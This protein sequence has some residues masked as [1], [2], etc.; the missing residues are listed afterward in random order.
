MQSVGI[1]KFSRFLGVL[2]ATTGRIV[3]RG[4]IWSW[5]WEREFN[6]LIRDQR[7]Q[8]NCQRAKRRT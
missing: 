2:R 8:N 5:F 1:S 4:N 6:S 3:G 7:R